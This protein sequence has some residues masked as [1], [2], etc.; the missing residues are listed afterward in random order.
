MMEFLGVP[1]GRVFLEELEKFVQNCLGGSGDGCV[2]W[3][4]G[5]EE[6]LT[7]TPSEGLPGAACLGLNELSRCAGFRL[8]PVVFREK[9]PWPSGRGSENPQVDDVWQNCNRSCAEFCEN[10]K[11]REDPRNLASQ[12]D[13]SQQIGRLARGGG[14]QRPVQGGK[15][16]LVDVS[17]G[18]CFD[19]ISGAGEVR[20]RGRRGRFGCGGGQAGVLGHHEMQLRLVR[21]FEGGGGATALLFAVPGGGVGF[22]Q[23]KKLSQYSFGLHRI[24]LLGDWS[25][26]L[27][28]PEGAAGF[29]LRA[30][31]AD[32]PSLQAQSRGACGGKGCFTSKKEKFDLFV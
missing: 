28:A 17:P 12:D 27:S 10:L 30:W 18:L 19:G 5:V 14:P 11:N 8:Y 15:A 22:E 2:F 3:L 32:V 13:K 31:K 7:H 6:R 26:I 29:R 24:G 1:N 20:R 21:V 16:V 25:G 23:I 9:P 4:E